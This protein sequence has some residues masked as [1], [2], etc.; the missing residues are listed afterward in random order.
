MNSEPILKILEQTWNF[1]HKANTGFDM[2]S[3][4]PNWETCNRSLKY[5]STVPL[6]S[7]N[8]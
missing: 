2:E 6:L 1:R 4:H 5:G 3:A 8:K 7:G